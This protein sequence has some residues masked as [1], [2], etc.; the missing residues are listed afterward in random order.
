MTE[1]I[2]CSYLQDD[3][4]S[5]I[6]YVCYD[7]VPSQGLPHEE[8]VVLSVLEG[9][10]CSSCYRS[11][12]VVCNVE[13]NAYLLCETLRKSSEERSAA[14]KVDTVLHDVRIKLWRCLLEHM[15]DSCL[16]TSD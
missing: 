5:C 9:E 2:Q 14:G 10:A 6:E 7:T 15:E 12:R 8:C 11:E 3:E 1:H 16:D 4:D 13:R